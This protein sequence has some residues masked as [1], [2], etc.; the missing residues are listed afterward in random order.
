MS[1]ETVTRADYQVVKLADGQLPRY[2]RG[3]PHY[4]ILVKL[5]TQGYVAG[6]PAGDPIESVDWVR[7]LL[8]TEREV[9]QIGASID[10]LGL[11]AGS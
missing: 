9:K 5:T 8:L 3:T 2:R 4:G 1:D 11:G 7:G 10:A 6:E